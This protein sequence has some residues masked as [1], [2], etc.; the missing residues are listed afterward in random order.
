MEDARG[1]DRKRLQGWSA[2]NRDGG[3]FDFKNKHID[4]ILC[5]KHYKTDGILYMKLNP[6]R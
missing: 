6:F 2:G 3:E 4:D 5:I 1:G